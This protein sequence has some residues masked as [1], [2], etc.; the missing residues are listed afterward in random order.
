MNMFKSLAL[1]STLLL[2]AE[3]NL[4]LFRKLLKEKVP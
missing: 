2:K 4:L 1:F 3:I